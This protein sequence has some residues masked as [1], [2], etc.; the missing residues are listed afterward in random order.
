MNPLEPFLTKKINTPFIGL[1]KVRHIKSPLI[2][3][4]SLILGNEIALHKNLIVY[5][6]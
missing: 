4:Q 6:V 3:E 5:A 1:K 2:E